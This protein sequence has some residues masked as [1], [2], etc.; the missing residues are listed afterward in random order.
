MRK[1]ILPLILCLGLTV[2]GCGKDVTDEQAADN[3]ASAETDI[4]ADDENYLDEEVDDEL[5]E[6]DLRKQSAS[7]DSSL[8]PIEDWEEKW[9]EETGNDPYQREPFDESLYDEKIIDAKVAELAKNSSS[10]SDEMENADKIGRSL[11]SYHYEDITQT[12]MNILS[13]YEGYFWQQEMNSLLERLKKE[14]DKKA[15]E[16]DQKTWEDNFKK[17]YALTEYDEG[18]WASMKNSGL[19]AQYYSNRCYML[20]KQLSDIRKDSYKLPK[21][22]FEDNSYVGEDG[23]LDISSGMEGGSIAI[24]YKDK[25]GN[26]TSLLVYDSYINENTIVFDDNIT[27][28]T[29][30]DESNE[31]HVSGTITYGWDGATIKIVDS[32]DEL[33]PS[34]TE[35]TFSTAL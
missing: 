3:T 9:I 2:S 32:K 31:F 30:D 17:C 19:Y 28:W 22:Y 25:D 6:D 27:V 34:G 4:N 8:L 11:Q 21:R 26:E 10:I 24:S 18:S 1:K 7:K 33:L 23:I 12:D 29:E 13:Y 14:G 35:K 5:S 16:A 20:A 15:V